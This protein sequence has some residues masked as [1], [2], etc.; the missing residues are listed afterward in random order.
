MNWEL[1]LTGDSIEELN[2]IVASLGPETDVDVEVTADADDERGNIEDLS[3][4]QKYVLKA[5]R[6]L[7]D[8]GALRVVHRL[9]AEN[10]ESPF[11]DYNSDNGWNEERK[12]VRSHLQALQRKGLVE[13]EKQTWIAAERAESD[14]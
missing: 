6:E 10:E 2:Q 11:D 3:E 4:E 8:G 12:T 7:P 14:A 9:A 13:R 5:L 1:K